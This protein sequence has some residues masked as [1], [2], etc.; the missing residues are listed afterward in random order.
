[1]FAGNDPAFA[2]VDIAV[3]HVAGLP[4]GFD[5]AVVPPAPHDIAGYV[6]EDD[7][8][9]EV[10]P[11][12]AFG[13]FEAAADFFDVDVIADDCAESL[14]ADF[15]VHWVLRIPMAYICVRMLS[16]R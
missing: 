15:Y 4:P 5:A 11:D 12:G 2:V 8:V 10:V 16:G 6:A 1:M 9:F 14:V 3:G 7:V 13:E